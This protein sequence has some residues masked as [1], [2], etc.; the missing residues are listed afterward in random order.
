MSAINAVIDH[1]FVVVND[2]RYQLEFSLGS[3]YKVCTIAYN[4]EYNRFFTVS[5]SDAWVERGQLE[6]CMCLVSYSQRHKVE[7]L[8]LYTNTHRLTTYTCTLYVTS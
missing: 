8:L 7:Q 2:I 4:S 5:T 1:P 6:L 3:D